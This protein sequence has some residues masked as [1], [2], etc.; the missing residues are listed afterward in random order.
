MF[1]ANSFRFYI[2]IKSINTTRTWCS[3]HFWI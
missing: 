2:L 3:Q 1:T